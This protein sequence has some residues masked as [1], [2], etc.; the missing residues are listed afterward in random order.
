VGGRKI[1]DWCEIQRYHDAGHDRDACMARFGFG[2]ASWYKA[3]SL[4]RL[5]ARD[6][7]FVFDWDAVQAFYNLGHTYSECRAQFGFS[8]GAWTKA[9]MCGVLVTRSKRFTLARLLAESKSRWSIKRRLLEAGVLH[10]KCD[11]CGISTWRGR[12]LS[13]QLH[14]CN[15]LRN[16][17][18]IENLRMLC[19]NC[20]SQTPSFAARNKEKK[21]GGLPYCNAKSALEEI[22]TFADISV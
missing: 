17:H 10:N 15:G 5:N 6:Q 20:H 16:D 12:P 8:P 9:V 2:I 4:G 7:R 3:N 1:Y 18:R 13:I 19:P 21:G 22:D 11:E 14:H